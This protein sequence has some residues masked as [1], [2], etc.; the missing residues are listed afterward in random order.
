MGTLRNSSASPQNERE[1]ERDLRDTNRREDGGEVLIGFWA[2]EHPGGLPVG[3]PGEENTA[4]KS[5]PLDAAG[6]S[7]SRPVLKAAA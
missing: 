3:L 4:R 2:G 5:G 1:R 6:C 7:R